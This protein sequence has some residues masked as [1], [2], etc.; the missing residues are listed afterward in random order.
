MLTE[1]CASVNLVLVH[2]YN[3]ICIHLVWSRRTHE[4]LP[5]HFLYLAV[6]SNFGCVKCLGLGEQQWSGDASVAN[7]VTW[8]FLNL[9]HGDL[10]ADGVLQEP[11][12]GLF[13]ADRCFRC[14]FSSVTLFSSHM[15]SI[16]LM[17][18]QVLEVRTWLFR[19]RPREKIGNG[20]FI[21]SSS[22]V[23][24]YTTFN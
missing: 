12:N 14:I 11:R 20:K 2:L 1:S 4:M 7:A 24:F 19:Q 10:R 18:L 6:H 3:V 22:Q 15:I 8:P 21:S 17:Q 9:S 13:P 23:S 5:C 16:F